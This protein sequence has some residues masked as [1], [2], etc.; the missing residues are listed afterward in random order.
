MAERGKPLRLKRELAPPIKQ[1][2][3]AREPIAKVLVDSG[4]LHIDQEFD[5]LVPHELSEIAIPGVV[6]K[7]PFNR[8]RVLGVITSRGESSEFKGELR[9]IAEAI[10]PYPLIMKNVL[11]LAFDV[12]RYYGGTRWDSL[13]FALPTF[14]KR[15]TYSRTSSVMRGSIP[16]VTDSRY[17]KRFWELLQSAPTQEQRIRAWWKAPPYEDPF[18]FLSILI[19]NSTS[20]CLLLLPDLEDVERMV[21]KLERHP[22]FDQVRITKWHSKLTRTEREANFHEIPLGESRVIVGVRGALFLPIQGLDLIIMW[23]EGADTYSEQR[24]PYFHAREVAVMRAHRE[25]THLI[26]GGYAPS[27]QATTYLQRGYFNLI[28]AQRSSSGS[29]MVSVRGII[30]D[31]DPNTLGRIPTQAWKI[32]KDGLSSGPVIIQVPQRGY[33]LSLSCNVCRNRATCSCGGKLHWSNDQNSAECTLCGLRIRNWICRYCSSQRLRYGQ[34]GDLRIV[35]ELGKAFPNQG[36]IS[37]NKDH[38]VRTVGNSPLIVVSTPGAEP[39]A[40]EGY[41]AGVVLNSALVLD[42]ATLDAEE[43][44]RRRWFG[45]T[46]LLKPNAPIFIDANLN[47]RNLQAL[48]RWDSLGIAHREL[49]ERAALNLPPVVK[50]VSLSGDYESIMQILRELPVECEVSR[51]NFHSTEEPTVLVRVKSPN[52]SATIEGIFQLARLQSASGKRVVR[53]K[54]DPISL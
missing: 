26:V 16:A 13:R 22:S 42:R 49:A 29:N 36:I 32:I 7:V 33:I 38:R 17:P 25:K 12:K 24:A 48:Q 3:A 28:E 53:I 39:L 35:E 51:P 44:A 1:S 2:P 14:G 30:N 40:A 54:V 47:N 9:F 19:S 43:E 11:D 21:E 18:D 52:P 45:L 10:R 27:L 41:S 31:S 8:K 50:M 5:F 34:V 46:T 23:D 37:S 6:V 20:R 15:T 4:L